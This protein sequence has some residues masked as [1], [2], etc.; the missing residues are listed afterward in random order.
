MATTH[1]ERR[2]GDWAQNASTWDSQFPMLRFWRIPG[3]MLRY[4]ATLR[5]RCHF[6][7]EMALAAVPLRPERVPD[8]TAFANPT[9][10]LGRL[11]STLWTTNEMAVRASHW[12][13]TM[14]SRRTTCGNDSGITLQRARRVRVFHAGNCGCRYVGKSGC[15]LDRCE[16]AKIIV[17]NLLQ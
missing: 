3:P 8:M 14:H 1:H 7:L 15:K 12:R 4:F 16:E 13:A 6:P 9:D 17:W 2:T 5:T 11:E 10:I